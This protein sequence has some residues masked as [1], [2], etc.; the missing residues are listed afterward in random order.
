MFTRI[1]L[2]KQLAISKMKPSTLKTEVVIMCCLV[3]AMEHVRRRS[4]RAYEYEALVEVTQGEDQRN[5]NRS[6]FH[7]CFFDYESPWD[8]TGDSAV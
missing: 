8:Q 1:D 5:S 2:V 4:Y 7:L 3:R 6:L